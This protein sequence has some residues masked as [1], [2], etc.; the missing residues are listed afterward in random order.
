MV[1]L[2]FCCNAWCCNEQQGRRAAQVINVCRA[3]YLVLAGR[4]V[5]Y[6]P[7]RAAWEARAQMV[8]HEHDGEVQRHLACEE[9]KLRWAQRHGYVAPCLAWPDHAHGEVE[10]EARMHNASS[11]E[12]GALLLRSIAGGGEHLE[13]CEG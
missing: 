12:A 13:E 4:T 7:P 9:E 11:E 6:D 5:T 2:P 10:A 3:L 1:L 8:G